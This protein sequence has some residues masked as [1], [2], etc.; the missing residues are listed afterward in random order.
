[1]KYKKIS[2]DFDD[3]TCLF[4]SGYIAGMGVRSTFSHAASLCGIFNQ[5]WR[6]AVEFATA[7]AAGVINFRGSI[8]RGTSSTFILCSRAS[9]AAEEK[10][11]KR[12]ERRRRL[13]LCANME[14]RDTPGLKPARR[15]LCPRAAH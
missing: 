15:A 2:F 7:A 13:C 11:K 5:K 4:L 1:M 12:E 6:R 3:R 9:R 14:E 8:Q 10:R